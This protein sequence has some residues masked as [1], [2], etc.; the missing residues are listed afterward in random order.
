MTHAEAM[1]QARLRWGEAG[2]ARHEP[3][4]SEFRV[5]K[6]IGSVFWVKGVGQ[7]WEEAFQAADRNAQN[8]P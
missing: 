4:S 5:G 8:Q 7:S 6:Q 3:E 1:Q 2:R